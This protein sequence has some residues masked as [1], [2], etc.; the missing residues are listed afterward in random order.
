VKHRVLRIVM[1][2]VHEENDLHMPV[3]LCAKKK[4]EGEDHRVKK[5]LFCQYCYKTP[6]KRVHSKHDDP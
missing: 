4:K 2:R 3:H 5:G 1:K 6:T